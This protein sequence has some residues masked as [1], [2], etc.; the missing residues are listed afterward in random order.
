M[1]GLR[2][3]PLVC[4]LTGLIGGSLLGTEV[5]LSPQI[6]GCLLLATGL[7]CRS[8]P[9]LSLQHGARFVLAG[10]ILAHAVTCWHSR[11]LPL[12]HIAHML[13]AHVNQR[14]TVEGSL[15]RPTES[16]HERQRLYLRLS[17][18]RDTT[19]WRAVTGRIRLNVHAT[20]LP[21]LPGDTVRITRLR[22]HRVRGFLNPG[23]FAFRRFMR[24]Q[25]L[26]VVGGVSNPTRLTLLHQGRG[27]HLSRMLVQWRQSLQLL[28]QTH[29][30][31]PESAV[32]LAMILG[33]RNLLPADIADQFQRTGT[34]H[35]L[36]VSGLHVGFLTAVFFLGLRM[37]LRWARSWLPRT[38][39]PSWRPTPVAALLC[40]PPM[41]LYCSL[42]GWKISTTRAALMVSS[43]MLAVIVS[44][45]RAVLHALALAAALI[46]LFDPRAVSSLGFQ[47]SFAAVAALALV[48]TR[49]WSQ[50]QLC[51]TSQRWRRRL[52]AGLLGSSAAYFATLPI[53]LGAFHTIPTYGIAA[54][55]ML[56]PLASILIPAG[57][58]GTGLAV[59]SP[60]LAPA[61]F[62][63]LAL[64]VSCITGVVHYIATL[65]GAQ[66]HTAAL[67]I[68]SLVGYY[69]LLVLALY[70]TGMRRRL[71][72]A[73]VCAGLLVAGIGW[74]YL[75]ARA[76]E[77]RITFLAVGTGD[78]IVIQAPG[79]HNILIDGGGTYDGRFDI[80]MRVVAP[81][82]WQQ[83]IRRFDLLALSHTHPNHARGL[84][85]ILRHFPTSHLLTNGSPLQADYFQDLAT[86][87]GRWGTELHTALA[88]PRQWRWG[89]LQLS[90]LSPP[91]TEA[92]QPTS[93][94]PPTENDRGLVLLLQYG[95]TR[96]LFTSD[97][98]HATER[99]L[100]GHSTALHADI[101][102]IPHHGSRTS[103]L[104][105]FVE[106][107]RPQ[108]GIIS[109]GAGNPYG[110]PHPE[111]LQTLEQRHIQIYRTDKHGAV[112]I[113]SDGTRYRVTPFQP[114]TPPLPVLIPPQQ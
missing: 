90:V 7:V 84:I 73:G 89:D 74:H 11:A 17:R 4:L 33:Q 25:H 81:F 105:A 22:L 21:F 26:Y 34:A 80:G 49:H 16:F 43:Y 14:L 102:Q 82:L 70:P 67:P 10:I 40:I 101:L 78:A 54:N 58:I 41:L 39:R 76:H 88:G 113:T 31:S 12:N 32:F 92:S 28:I 35:L 1:L 100:L 62:P 69:A 56:M 110:H 99:W 106:R 109:A 75:G 87:S 47:L 68:P 48:S 50:P 95:A 103:T 57:V 42:V 9:Y 36:V 77:L 93:W 97:I 79:N 45:P 96:V 55:I 94:H 19:G 104:P 8:W 44:R 86:I 112:T 46:L 91:A 2:L 61:I 64:L 63:P 53:L 60:L 51:T 66:F 20:A 3:N 83:H 13:P 59:F 29:L 52:T 111:V 37:L 15:Y 24:H 98:Q 65:P 27:W 6:I 30:K 85:S 38:W 72:Y 5:S 18:L 71:P 23:G 108:V 107:V 114:Y